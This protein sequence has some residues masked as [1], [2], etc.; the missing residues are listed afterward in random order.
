MKKSNKVVSLVLA[1]AMS[2][3]LMTGCGPSAEANVAESTQSVVETI[4]PLVV[5]KDTNR[6][7][8]YEKM[9]EVKVFEPGEHVYMIRYK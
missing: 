5:D 2:T 9:P 4:A 3:G 1:L 7:H 8:S 6:V